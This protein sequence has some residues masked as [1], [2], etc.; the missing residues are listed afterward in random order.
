MTD[1]FDVRSTQ[2]L[3]ALFVEITLC[4]YVVPMGFSFEAWKKYHKKHKAS[5][6]EF[7]RE[8]PGRKFKVVHGHKRGM[9]GKALPGLSDVSY[10]KASRAHRGIAMHK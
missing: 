3:I 9:V 10:A 5:A 2:N 1:S 4:E 6:A 8:H 7:A